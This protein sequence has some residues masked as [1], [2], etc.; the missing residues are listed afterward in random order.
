MKRLPFVYTKRK[1]FLFELMTK[2]E[3]WNFRSY[4]ERKY[5]APFRKNRAYSHRIKKN[6]GIIIKKECCRKGK[7]GVF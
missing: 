2:N 3:K 7:Y 1:S 5:I 6:H 4:E